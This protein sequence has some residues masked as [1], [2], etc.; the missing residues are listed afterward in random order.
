M[1][2][3]PLPLADS[4][5]VLCVDDTPANLDVLW[6]TLEPRGY[7][8]Q[9]APSG[10]AAL[11]LLENAPPPDLILMDV[12]MPGIDGY[13][14]C[15]RLKSGERTRDIP[16]LFVTARNQPEDI[17]QAFEAGGVDYI[18]KPFRQEEV[19]ARVAAHIGIERLRRELREQN[20]ALEELSEQ[21]SRFVGMAAHDLRNPLISIRGFAELL[22]D[23]EDELPAAERRR[24]LQTIERVSGDM[25]GLINDMLDVTTIESGKLEL[26]MASSSLKQL[27]EERLKI[28]EN[29]AH[30]K[31]IALDAELGETGRRMLDGA[32]IIQVFDNLLSNAIKFSPENTRIKI[33][34]AQDA[35]SDL[36]T[37]ADEGPGI[38]E[39]E[40]ER[41]FEAFEKLSA[42][43]TG[44]ESST[45]LGLAIAKK[46]IEGHGGS[47][48]VY[49]VLGEGASF[50]FR[51][52]RE[53][54]HDGN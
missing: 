54:N 53:I 6:R 40:Q 48:E 31:Q 50:S 24:L 7:R 49:S 23:S 43:P 1:N 19:C 5:T 29:I 26:S 14:T 12:M 52:P 37:V 2:K 36:V 35:E 27:I 32:R 21:K 41:L 51:L 13:E 4:Q 15:R 42:R 20:S 45:G 25:L 34:L 10:E 47:L 33:S 30:R 39:Q 16:V 22:L 38:S 3:P 46:M 18:P 28:F 11:K 17:V 8:I 44:G 9:V